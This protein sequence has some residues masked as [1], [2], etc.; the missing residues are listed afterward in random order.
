MSTIRGR[1][2]RLLGAV[3]LVAGLLLG[4]SPSSIPWWN[5][6][7]KDDLGL[8]ADQSAKIRQI[9]RSYRSKLLDA[10]NNANKAQQ[11]LEDM[12]NDPE[13][14]P[15]EAEQVISRLAF[16][17]SEST[18]VFLEMSVELRSLLTL[19]QW[20]TLVRRWED[21]KNKKPADTLTP[22]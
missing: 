8:S 18:K 10:R 21:V 12:M 3:L 20:R 22:P 9:V 6:P 14:K 4:Q 13:V 11:D 16:A 1:A 5:S 2:V 7:V 15:K 17:R 19:D